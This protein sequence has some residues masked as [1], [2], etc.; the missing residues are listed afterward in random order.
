MLANYTLSTY[1]L[2]FEDT[3][4]SDRIFFGSFYSLSLILDFVALINI[5]Q[6]GIAMVG[7]LGFL[8]LAMM[9][10]EKKLRSKH[11]VL[12]ITGALVLSIGTSVVWNLYVKSQNIQDLRS[13]VRGQGQF[14][15]SKIDPMIYLR[16]LLRRNPGKQQDTLWHMIHE[17]FNRM[18]IPP[19]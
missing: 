14:A 5:K 11:S 19:Q 3:I 13:S 2:S 4:L 8:A 12:T 7:V 1:N 15:L 16:C 17:L 18:I 9:I 10:A 6:V